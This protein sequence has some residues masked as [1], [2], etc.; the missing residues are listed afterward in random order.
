MRTAACF[1]EGMKG[2]P[3]AHTPAETLM[4][5]RCP[6]GSPTT[7]TPLPAR[8]RLA[9]PDAKNLLRTVLAQSVNTG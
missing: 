5:P 6:S 3:G 4:R 8:T 7:R 1:E 2:R 9:V